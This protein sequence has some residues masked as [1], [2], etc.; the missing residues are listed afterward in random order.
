MQINKLVKSIPIAIFLDEVD[1]LVAN[2]QHFP[3]PQSKKTRANLNQQA[4]QKHPYRDLF[5]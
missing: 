5:R 4:S 3:N 2:L 1:I